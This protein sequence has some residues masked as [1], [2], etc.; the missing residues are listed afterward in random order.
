MFKFFKKRRLMEELNY[1]YYMMNVSLA[2]WIH[3]TEKYLESNADNKESILRDM[4]R[5]S[6]E[7]T[8]SNQKVQ[9]ILIEIEGL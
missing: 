5:A 1:A 2:C 8:R 7:F 6:D 3:S 9:A 4:H